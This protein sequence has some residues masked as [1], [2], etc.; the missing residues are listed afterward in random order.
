MIEPND[1]QRELIDSTDGIFLVDA[2]AGT[3]KTF[4]VTRRYANIIDQSDVEPGDVLLVTFTNN[5]ATE[6]KE[7]IVKRSRYGMRELADAPIQT[8]HSLCHDLLEEHGHTAPAYLGIDD[9][10]TSSTRIIEDDLVEGALFSEFIDRFSDDHPEY[11]DI[12]RAISNPDDLLGLIEQLTAKGVFPAADGWYRDSERHLDG[13]FEAFRRLFDELNE[14]RNDGTKQSVLRSKLN[15]YGKNKCYLPNA[16]AKGEIRGSGKRAPEDLA[17]RVFEEERD[18]LK[19]FVHDVYYEYLQFALR[20]N[21]L[22]FGFLQL[23]A[24]VLLC[25]RHELR[26]DVAFDYVMVDE[27]QDTSEIQFKLS[28]LLAGKNNL[29]VVGDWKQSIYGFQYADVDNIVDFEGRLHR[30][31]DHLNADTERITFVPKPITTIELVEN[32]RS[33]QSILDFSEHGLLVPAAN[34]DE[35]DVEAT[36]ERIVSLNANSEHE[37]SV[38]EAIQSED[39]HEAVL[40]KIRDV[41]GN[42]AYRVQ[43]EDG[44]LRPPEFSDIAVLTRTRNFGRELLQTAEE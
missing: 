2:G 4:A 29:C 3:G 40:S 12:F 36:R 10:I 15:R 27:F 7:R 13:D 6:M 32:Y 35:V 44:D 43:G 25:E 38:I 39:E 31:V 1:Q 18:D 34:R 19:E 9:H 11:D 17:R 16:P 14:L 42:D 37:N 5:A 20:R 26:E 33:T 23:F 24:F 30:F 28:L 8:F 21:Y 22:N 41:V